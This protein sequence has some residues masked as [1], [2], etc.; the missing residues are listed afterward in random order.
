[1]STK[2]VA[3][4][5]KREGGLPPAFTLLELLVFSPFIQ[6]LAVKTF[7]AKRPDSAFSLIE[8][9]IALGIV[10]FAV[11]AVLGVIVL[12]PTTTHSTEL[13]V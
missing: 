13:S 10:T 4:G 3:G 12:Q 2:R 1:M 8:V 7:R 5:R 6:L 11:V 9:T